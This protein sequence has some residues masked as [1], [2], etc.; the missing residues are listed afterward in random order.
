SHRQQYRMHRFREPQARPPHL[1]VP[2]GTGSVALR[3]CSLRRNEAGTRSPPLQRSRNSV[4][5]PER[6]TA[7]PAIVVP[8]LVT[9]KNAISAILAPVLEITPGRALPDSYLAQQP[10][11]T[12]QGA[13]RTYWYA[14]SMTSAVP[15][16]SFALP[17]HESRRRRRA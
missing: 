16:I 17:P 15:A 11:H 1:L 6:P 4:D 3:G 2:R 9:R 10:T 14:R 8:T 12:A 5:V 13:N 7:C